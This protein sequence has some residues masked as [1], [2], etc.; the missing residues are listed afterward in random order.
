[1]PIFSLAARAFG[2][3]TTL[4]PHLPW[5]TEVASPV[6]HCA[7]ASEL[8]GDPWKLG[9]AIWVAGFLSGIAFTIFC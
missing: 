3:A 5:L 7:A 2:V 6:L 8:A 9:I 4:L 1:M